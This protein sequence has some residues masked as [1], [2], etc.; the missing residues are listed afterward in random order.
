M[1]KGHLCCIRRSRTVAWTQAWMDACWCPAPNSVAVVDALPQSLVVLS[2]LPA[3]PVEP[4]SSSTFEVGQASNGVRELAVGLLEHVFGDLQQAGLLATDVEFGQPA[5]VLDEDSTGVTTATAGD[6][7]RALNAGDVAL[8]D[9]VPE[10]CLTYLVRTVRRGSKLDG[11][12]S[13]LEGADLAGLDEFYAK[14][15]AKVGNS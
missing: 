12:T 1:R 15:A 5:P 6:L 14:E 11:L 7:T 13:D 10:D 3:S 2:A 8:A 9:W 4:G